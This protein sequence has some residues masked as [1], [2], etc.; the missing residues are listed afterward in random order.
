MRKVNLAAAKAR[1]SELVAAAA[2][3]ETVCIMRRGK[4]VAWLVAGD[5]ARRRIDP[6][7]LRELTEAMPMQRES[8]ADLV[9]RMRD[10]ERY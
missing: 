6:A 3:G 5:S 8:A 2:A 7:A 4:P 10:G 9:R 1:L